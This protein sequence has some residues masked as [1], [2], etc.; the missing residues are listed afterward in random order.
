MACYG[1]SF[2]LLYFSLQDEQRKQMNAGT[3]EIKPTASLGFMQKFAKGIHLL[4]FLQ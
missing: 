1:D 2:T 4:N 3:A